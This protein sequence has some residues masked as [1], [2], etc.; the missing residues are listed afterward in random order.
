MTDA[1]DR[2]VAGNHY[3]DFAIQPGHFAIENGLG[4]AQGNIVKYICRYDRPGRTQRMDDLRKAEHYIQML[5]EKELKMN[6]ILECERIQNSRDD[7][8][9]LS[10]EFKAFNELGDIDISEEELEKELKMDQILERERI[11]NLK[12]DQYRLSKEFKAFTGLGDI[13]ISEEVDD[14]KVAAQIRQ[15]NGC[16]D[17]SCE[18]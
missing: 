14:P 16:E 18:A 3:K 8:Y 11:Q 9:R 7:Q 4:F 1:F 10:K 15:A 12:D 5:I 2:Q 17:G 6:P 13:D